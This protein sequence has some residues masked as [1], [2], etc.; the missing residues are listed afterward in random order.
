M[1]NIWPFLDENQMKNHF[2]EGWKKQWLQISCNIIA[3]M[4]KENVN[5]CKWQFNHMLQICWLQKTRFLLVDETRDEE[6]NISLAHYVL[7]FPKNK[8][9]H[10]GKFKRR[11]FGPYWIQ[12]CFCNNIVFVITIDKFDPNCILVNINK[13]KPYQMHEETPRR[14]E[15]QIERGKESQWLETNFFAKILEEFFS[16]AIKVSLQDKNLLL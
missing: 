15:A 5:S 11:W 3:N 8:K 4:T 16:M 1:G 6:K 10:L 7:R 2:L 12:Y 9:S 14:L 13:L